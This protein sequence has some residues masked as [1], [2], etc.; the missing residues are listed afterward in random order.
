MY[1]LTATSTAGDIS[2]L[3]SE[4]NGDI[5]TADTLTSGDPITGQL[6]SKTDIDVYS[7]VTNSTGIIDIDFN[8]PAT[9]S[10]SGTEYFTVTLSDDTN[11]IA[12]Q[13]TGVDTSFSAGVEAGTYYVNVSPHIDHN[14][15][16]YHS[17]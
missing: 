16:V 11:T 7:I 13:N 15:S 9:E 4:D 14:S 12:S 6:S 17:H 5:S 10:R 1:S 2:G 3:E 8:S